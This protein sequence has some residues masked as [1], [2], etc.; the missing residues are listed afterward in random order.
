M[1]MTQDQKAKVFRTPSS[2][3]EELTH[4]FLAALYQKDIPKARELYQTVSDL[5]QAQNLSEIDEKHLRQIQ[6]A[7]RQILTKEEACPINSQHDKVQNLLRDRARQAEPQYLD[8]ETWEK[9]LDLHPWQLDLI[10]KTAVTFQLTSGCSNFCR[11]CNE[12]ALPRPRAHFTKDAALT[13]IQKLL[14]QG[15][16]DLALYGGSDPLDWEDGEYSLEDLLKEADTLPGPTPCFSLLTKIPRGRE[17]RLKSLVRNGVELAVSLTN[18]N[19]DRIEKL[20]KEL[21][22]RLTKQH[23]TADLL[24]PACLDED[25]Q[26]IKPS[27]TDAYGTEISLD[28]AFIIIPTFTSALYPF[29]HKKIPITKDTPWFPVKKLGRPALLQDYFKPLQVMGKGGRSYYLDHLLDVQVENI[30][31]DNGEYDLT[32]PGMRSIKEYFEIFDEKAR[33]KRRSMTVS[34]MRRLKKEY[35]GDATFAEINPE[36]RAAYLEQILAHLDFC[37]KDVVEESRQYAADYFRKSVLSYI[38]DPASEI[39]QTALKTLILNE[40]IKLK[41]N[42]DLCKQEEGPAWILFRSSLLELL[43]VESEASPMPS[44]ETAARVVYST[45]LDRFI[46]A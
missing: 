22:Q 25:F 26:T 41:K 43:W 32:P 7:V 2:P 40:F 21:G 18:R 44:A 39:K 46:P 15:N 37:R 16:T 14:E 28:G 10:F 33:L 31:L 8:Y 38:S 45:E 13:I 12:W 27:I 6:V 36:T 34:V 5:A 42:L 17:T 9:R 20:E 23:A 11:R 3:A 30:L 1:P 4:R 29:G 35:L 19:R 24:I